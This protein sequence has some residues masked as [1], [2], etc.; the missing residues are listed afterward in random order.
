V[1]CTKTAEPIDIPFWTKTRESPKNYALDGVQIPQREW[2]IFGGSRAGHSKPL[3]IFAAAVAAAFAVKRIIQ[4]PITSRSRRDHLVCQTRAN[5]NPENYER[6][7]CGLSASK[8]V[9]GVHSAGEV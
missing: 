6:R 5:R 2:A 1:S 3:A 8:G 9:T 4:L 7:Q